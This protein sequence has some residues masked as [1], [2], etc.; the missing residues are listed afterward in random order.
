MPQ[1]A[2]ARF[3]N[4][5]PDAAGDACVLNPS[6]ADVKAVLG[7]YN[8]EP[9]YGIDNYPLYQLVEGYNAAAR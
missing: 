1:A 8:G 3:R 4:S 2:H 6:A 5:V 9:Q 7:K